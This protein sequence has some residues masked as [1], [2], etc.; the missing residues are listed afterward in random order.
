MSV[1]YGTLVRLGPLPIKVFP[2]RGA[3]LV[4]VRRHSGYRLLRSPVP[5]ENSDL[6]EKIGIMP[7]LRALS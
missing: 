5:P 4:R 7:F 3:Q 6:R 2:A 1:D